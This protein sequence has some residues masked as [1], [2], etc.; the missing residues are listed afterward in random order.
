MNFGFSVAGL[1][2]AA[3]LTRWPRSRRR[4]LIISVVVAAAVLGS[5]TA[6]AAVAQ[7]QQ[8][9]ANAAQQ[10]AHQ[11]LVDET[12]QRAA[13]AAQ[14]AAMEYLKTEAAA[15][16]LAAQN[17]AA[18]ALYAATIAEA[19][20]AS[21]ADPSK[22]EALKLAHQRL[23]ADQSNQNAAQMGDDVQMIDQAIK[24]IGTLAQSQDRAYI[25]AEQATGGHVTD[26]ESATKA[27]RDFCAGLVSYGSD[28]T[29]VIV[30][31]LIAKTVD[32]PAIQVYC[33][34]LTTEL[35]AA[36]T[37]IPADN[38][39]LVAPT[40]TPLGSVP[41]IVGAGTY[42]T[43]GGPTNCYWEINDG[44]GNIIAN[45][46]AIAAPGGITVRLSSGRGFTTQGCGSWLS[47]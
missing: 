37:A 38:G 25:A 4:N 22:L 35:S 40:S 39:Y 26:P 44:H 24:D 45:N 47:Q 8:A 20:T 1:E 13:Q 2:I 23:L 15:H 12:R 17:D 34:N 11:K 41:Y 27:G 3:R 10:A 7:H 6:V 14:A 18:S 16:P 21:F 46:F 32:Q 28:P 9:V 19:A 33:P 30:Q 5:L 43:I 42:K 36:S 29:D 31:I